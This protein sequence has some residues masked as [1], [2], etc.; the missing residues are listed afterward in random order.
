MPTKPLKPCA[1]SGCPNLTDGIYCDKHK[2][3]DNRNY[4]KFHRDEKANKF[5]S[6]KEWRTLRK[7]FLSTHPLCVECIKEGKYTP[8]KIV[9]HIVPIRFGGKPL[10]ASNLQSLCWNCHTKKSNLEGS[11]GFHRKPK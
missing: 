10:D 6:S 4:T 1:V 8:A 11:S 7:A 2:K 3:E 5:Y 9:D